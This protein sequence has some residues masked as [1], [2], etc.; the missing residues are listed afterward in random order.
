MLGEFFVSFSRLAVFLVA[1]LAG[2][3]GTL[4]SNE[5]GTPKVNTLPPKIAPLFHQTKTVC[6]GRFMIDLPAS[7]Q[8]VWGPMWVP[9]VMEVY[10]GEGPTIE[11]EIKAKVDKITRIP[12]NEEP[13]ML[14]GVFDSVNPDSKIVVGYENPR[15]SLG[16][17]LYSYIR[18]GNTAFVQSRPRASL[19]VSV[20]WGGGIVPDKTVYKKKVA[21]LLNVAR[22]LRLRDE[23]EIPNE[24]GVCIE[25]GFIA[26]PLD[27]DS[28]RISI[29]FRFPE[30]PDVTLAI[31]TV[32]REWLN[33]DETLDARLKGGMQG[34]REQGLSSLFSRIR[35]LRKQNRAIGEWKGAELLARIPTKGWG[36]EVHQFMFIAQGV[37]KDMLRPHV[38][39]DFYSGVKDNEVGAT[40]ASL[41]DDEAIALWDKLTS[42]IRVRP[43]N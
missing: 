42:T 30:M 35:H 20:N 3:A 29:G 43:V 6:F 12:H 28:E 24:H 14:I 2:C 38:K 33:E 15:D 40:A 37:A 13:S 34:A 10:P 23:N 21:E 11:A 17:E 32:T 22:R 39:I 19:V 1:V 36:P 4:P 9:Y 7:A 41:T 26:L 16:A 31:M 25:E 5:V 18:L 8:L 27:F